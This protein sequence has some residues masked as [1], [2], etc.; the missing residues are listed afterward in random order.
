MAAVSV[1]IPLYPNFDSL[2]LCG[3]LQTFSFA[4]MD[5]HLIGPSTDRVVTS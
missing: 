2:D 3:P 1:G 5:C 4:G